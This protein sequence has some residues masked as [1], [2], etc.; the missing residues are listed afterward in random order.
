VN[1][2]IEK[3]IYKKK[4]NQMMKLRKKIYQKKPRHASLSDP[5]L[6]GLNKKRL[7]ARVCQ[8]RSGA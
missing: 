5:A 8:P 3:N 7:R 6:S 4:Q 2:K 1:N